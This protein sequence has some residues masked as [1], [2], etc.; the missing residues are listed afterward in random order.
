MERTE[1]IRY[2]SAEY[3]DERMEAHRRWQHA[4]ERELIAQVIDEVQELPKRAPKAGRLFEVL[5]EPLEVRQ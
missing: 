3:L 2:W 1:P 5:P 4:V